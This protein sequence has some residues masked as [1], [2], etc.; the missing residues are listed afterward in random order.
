MTDSTG[1]AP[2]GNDNKKMW[3]LI[4]AGVGL[5]VVVGMAVGGIVLVRALKSAADEIGRAHV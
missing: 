5:L 2:K 3:I 1:L 4:A